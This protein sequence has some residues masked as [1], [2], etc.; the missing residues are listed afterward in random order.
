MAKNPQNCTI[1]LSFY[2]I[3]YYYREYYIILS[4]GVF[5]CK[6][7]KFVHHNSFFRIISCDYLLLKKELGMNGKTELDSKRK[8]TL[9]SRIKET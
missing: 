5:N 4:V 7:P 9:Q 6:N 1:I 2:K 3:L 8:W